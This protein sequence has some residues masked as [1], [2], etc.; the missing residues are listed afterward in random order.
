M[1]E[2]YTDKIAPVVAEKWAVEREKHEDDLAFP[3]VPKAG[4]RAKIAREVFGTIPVPE[5]RAIAARAKDVADT[6]RKAYAQALKD[7]PSKSPADRQK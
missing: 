5:Q 1:V 4:F 6:A 2:S 3:K 7:P